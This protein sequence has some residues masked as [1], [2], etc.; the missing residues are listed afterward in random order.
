[1]L[2][3]VFISSENLVTCIFF[4]LNAPAKLTDTIGTFFVGDFCHLSTLLVHLLLFHITSSFYCLE[5]QI[6][7]FYPIPFYAQQWLNS[8]RAKKGLWILI[9]FPHL[10][11]YQGKYLSPKPSELLLPNFCASFETI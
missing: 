9:L 8:L 2:F 3:V 10:L 6:L 5:K 7:Y 1:M 4:L 11:C